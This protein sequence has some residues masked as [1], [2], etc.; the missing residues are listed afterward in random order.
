MTDT[1]GNCESPTRSQDVVHQLP[2]PFVTR[3][4]RT[5]S[6]SERGMQNPLSQG[7][8]VEFCRTKGHGFISVAGND[9]DPVFVHVSDIEGEFVP[10]PGDLVRFRLCPVP[11]KLDKH[12][13][14]H[15]Q[16]VDFCP[17]KHHRWNEPPTVEERQQA[18][19][20]NSSSFIN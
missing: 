20:Q 12:Q 17:A 6:T 1:D 19:R 11:P 15:V 13:A 14:I 5:K 4:V 8:I 18:Q 16:I 3:R 9:S 2:S 10:M 7:T